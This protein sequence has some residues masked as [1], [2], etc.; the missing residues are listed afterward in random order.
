MIVRL[1]G[2]LLEANFYVPKK[3]CKGGPQVGLLD[4]V[5]AVVEL[6]YSLLESSITGMGL[7][8]GFSGSGAVFSVV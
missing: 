8:R 2:F 5:R 3:T 7:L 6:P 4:I 1:L